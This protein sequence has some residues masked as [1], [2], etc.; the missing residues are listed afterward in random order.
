MRETH[1]TEWVLSLRVLPLLVFAAACAEEGA[2]GGSPSEPAAEEEGA[3]PFL[4]TDVT[5]SSGL[6]SFR[7]RNGDPDKPY[8]VD[9]IGGGV[10]FLDYDRDGDL[11]AYLTNGSS[12]DGFPAGEAP[13]D[14]LFQNGGAGK[15][16]DVSAE[17]GVGDELWTNGV[18]APDYDGDGYPDVYLCNFGANVL[19]RNRGDGTFADVSSASGTA[20]ASWSTGAAFFDPDLDG[21]LDLYVVNYLEFDRDFVPADKQ[22]CTYRGIMVAYGPRGLGLAPDNFYRNDGT[23]SFAEDTEAAGMRGAPAY[24]FQVLAFDFD[25]DG[26]TDVFVSNDSMENFFFVNDGEGR[27]EDRGMQSGLAV[28]LYGQSQAGMGAAVGDYNADGLP[29][30]YVTNFAQDYNTLYRNDGGGFFTDV[31]GELRLSGPTMTSLGWS[32]GFVDFDSDGD[33]DVYVSNGHL[34]PQIDLFDFGTSYR[35]RNQVFENWGGQR[36]VDVTSGSGPAWEDAQVS[37]GGAVGDIDGDGDPDLLIGNLDGPATLLR[38]D[39]PRAGAWISIRVIG[40]GG[41]RDAVGATLDVISGE[42]TQ[43][44][45]LGGLGGFLSAS[46]PRLHFGLGE[47]GG[48]AVRAVVHWPGGARESF[49][50]LAPERFH[51]LA[52]GAGVALP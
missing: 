21:D 15:F 14:A 18:A 26:D 50:G 37:R 41:N 43:R 44:K 25:V 27:F 12:L 11:D 13:R 46:D 34:Y 28:N 39:S 3:S 16:R 22:L 23:G 52:R 48:G 45:S 5:E 2:P 9:Q 1:R 8:I 31:T 7:Q 36:F 40:E 49:E 38:N 6:S 29:D 4:F 30:I 33:D 20:D 42:R 32:C 35:Q 47:W 24:G 51:E 17:A 19:L 10:A